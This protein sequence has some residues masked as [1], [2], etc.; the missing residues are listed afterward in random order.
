MAPE[1]DSTPSEDAAEIAEMT[2]KDSDYHIN[3][4]DKAMAGVERTNSQFCKKFYCGH[5]T[6][7]QHC[8][9]Q[10]NHS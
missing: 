9:L 6:V 10:T 4:L 2:T 5:N 7:K 3:L 8:M 1:M